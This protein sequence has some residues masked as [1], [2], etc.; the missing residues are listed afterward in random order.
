M[1]LPWAAALLLQQSHLEQHMG[2]HTFWGLGWCSC[3]TN[4]D[5]KQ[6]GHRTVLPSPAKGRGA[7][8]QL[9]VLLGLGPVLRQ[10]QKLTTGVSQLKGISC[11]EWGCVTAALSQGH[12]NNHYINYIPAS[13]L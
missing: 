11:V 9:Q 3:A 6:H 13:T 5:E 7:L 1:W 12:L 8:C 2:H 10:L 4:M